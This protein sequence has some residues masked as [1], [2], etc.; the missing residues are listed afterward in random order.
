MEEDNMSKKRFQTLIESRS[1]K[2]MFQRRT[3]G[4]LNHRQLARTRPKNMDERFWNFRL[5]PFDD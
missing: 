2:Q 3:M 5:I 1:E 4:T